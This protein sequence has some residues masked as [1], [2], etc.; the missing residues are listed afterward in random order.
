MDELI[1]C[2]GRGEVQ[3]TAE[4]ALIIPVM[5]HRSSHVALGEVHTDDDPVCALAEQLG[6]GR[7]E[8][9]LQREHMLAAAEQHLSDRLERMQAELIPALLL[10]TTQSS[11][12][13]GSRRV[14]SR[15]TVS[16]FTA[17]NSAS[18]LTGALMSARASLAASCTSTAT[19]FAKASRPG[20]VQTTPS[21]VCPR[22]RHSA[23]RKFAPAWRRRCLTTASLPRGL[24]PPRSLRVP[25]RKRGAAHRAEAP[26]R[27]HQTAS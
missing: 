4:L 19:V 1:H 25:G 10:Q 20:S 8:A 16:A 21:P 26:P 12:Q 23:V 5:L 9:R 14:D 6:S 22:T 2:R 15:D 27:D 18:W 17:G 11:Y 7:H 3:L 13:P 24:A